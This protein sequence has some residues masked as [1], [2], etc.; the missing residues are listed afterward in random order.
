MPERQTLSRF[1]HSAQVTLPIIN[2]SNCAVM[3]RL[4]G[5]GETRGCSVGFKLP[6]T[7]LASQ[8]D[9]ELG[10]GEAISIPVRVMLPLPPVVALRRQE[11]TFI[12]VTTTL[13]AERGTSRTLRGKV[14]TTPMIG[15]WLVSL[16]ILCLAAVMVF[17]TPLLPLL[18]PSGETELTET[19]QV[20][21]TARIAAVVMP[22]YLA[23][24]SPP[25][26]S[27]TETEDETEI[28][29]RQMFEDVARQY[30]LDWRIL[31]EIAYQESRFNPWAIGRYKEMGLM[32]IH[33]IT[34]NAWAPRVGVYD[35]YDPYS[36]TQ[37][38]A[39]YLAY[40]RKYCHSWGYTEDYWMLV[41]YNWGPDNL[42]QLFEQQEGW[43]QVPERPRQY[44]VRI[45]RFGT[46]S[47]IRRQK[48]LEAIVTGFP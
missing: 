1:K 26:R 32:Q 11:H 38:A 45:L 19:D 35:P 42:R 16:F 29:Y 4:V 3:F 24:N 6:D 47:P 13:L 30:D 39:A 37:V 48:Q 21:P 20:T 25:D 9:L 12:V 33:P 27:E 2:R 43:T 8:N 31:A 40:L 41:G 7:G 5:L 22:T 23:G 14:E 44:A 34:W 36:N 17:A 46:E 28:T 18:R 10:P 15:P